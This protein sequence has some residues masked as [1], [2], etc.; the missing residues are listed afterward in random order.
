MGK[1]TTNTTRLIMKKKYKRIV[2]VFT[3]ASFCHKTLAAGYAIWMKTDSGTYRHAAPFKVLINNA[4]EAETGAL[5]N[6]IIWAATKFDLKNSDLLVATSDC[7]GAIESVKMGISKN[8]LIKEFVLRVDKEIEERD[9]R[10][11]LRHVKAHK[12]YGTKRTA[13]NEWCDTSAKKIMRNE[14]LTK[15]ETIENDG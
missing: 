9:F 14:R 12:G 5:A 10:L 13:V 11:S 8:A 15:K 4:W 1:I 3:D 6:G 7:K 2:T